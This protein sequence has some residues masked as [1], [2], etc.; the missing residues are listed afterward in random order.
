MYGLLERQFAG[1]VA[2]AQKKPGITSLYLLQ[3]LERRLDNVVYRLGLADSRAQARQRVLHGHI[4]VNGR[5]VSIPSFLVTPGDMVTWKEKSKEQDFVK[6]QMQDAP[7]HPVPAWL[8]LD[9]AAMEGKV[10]KIPGAEE[11]ETKVDSRLIIEFYS[12]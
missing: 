4:R 2:K 7:Q 11:I 6:A 5:K 1:Y 8:S 3:T 10:L 9:A 12:R